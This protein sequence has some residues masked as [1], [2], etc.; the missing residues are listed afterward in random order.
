MQPERHA[1]EGAFFALNGHTIRPQVGYHRGT[2]TEDDH[3]AHVSL[4]QVVVSKTRIKTSLIQSIPERCSV[5]CWKCCG[6]GI[7]L[8]TVQIALHKIPQY[9]STRDFVRTYW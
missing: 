8:T 2:E 4:Q 3:F 5:A 1:I 7:V 6:R 9:T